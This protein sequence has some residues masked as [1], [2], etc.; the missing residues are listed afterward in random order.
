MFNTMELFD[1][2][3]LEKLDK[4]K[5]I[6]VILTLQQQIEQL[7][8]SVA[9]QAAEV[10]SLREQVA[11]NSRNSGKPPS[12]DGLR[13][14]RNLRQKSGRQPGGQKG[15]AGQTLKMVEQPEHVKVHTISTCD[16]CSSDLTLIEP[17]GY[18][19]RQ[20]FDIPA[21]RL[22]VTE[23]QAEIKVCPECECQVK[24]HFPAAVSHPVQYGARLKAQASYLNSYQLIPLARTCELLEDFYGHRPT[25]A[26]VL[27]ANSAVAHQIEPSLAVIKQ[28]LINA[29]V[30]HFDESGLRVEGKLHWLHV[31]GTK[32]LTYYGLHRKR[33]QAGHAGY[34]HFVAF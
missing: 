21:V 29:D 23:H 16:H 22:E 5:L 1:S 6:S 34:R 30:V 7:Q 18:E 12:S 10:Q 24:G 32:M 15:H 33:G 17:Y 2:D 20:V 8:E 31:A 14:P 13:K 3:Q 9:K 4:E 26:F 27:A 25:E 19:R 11:K 28:Q